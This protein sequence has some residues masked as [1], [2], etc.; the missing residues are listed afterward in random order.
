M[1]LS[2]L[3]LALMAVLS[4]WRG[5][6]AQ[7]DALWTG[8]SGL[9]DTPGNW[10]IN[11]V[12]INGLVTYNVA[13]PGGVAVQF[14]VDSDLFSPAEVADLDLAATS[15]LEINPG[16]VLHVLDDAMIGGRIV[17][18]G[19][20]TEFRADAPGA[21]F[22]GT[23]AQ[24][25]ASGGATIAVAGT[26]YDGTGITS[27]SIFSAAGAQSVVDVSS[28]Q[29]FD[30]LRDYGGSPVRTIS[31]TNGGLVDLSSLQTMQAGAGVGN[32]RLDVISNNAGVVDL[33]NLESITGGAIRFTS[34]DATYSLPSLTSIVGY[35]EFDLPIGSLVDLPEL[36]TQD[37]GTYELG[38]G[39]A[40]N[41][42][43]LTSLT[44]AALTIS[45]ATGTFTAPMLSVVD[46]SRLSVS[47]GKTLAI[48][49][50]SYLGT[51]IS[52]GTV[53][54]ADGG[55]TLLDL[56]TMTS[57]DLFRDFGG[58]PVRTI[59]ATN[60]GTIDLSGMTTLRGGA[61]ADNDRLDVV[62]TN[63]GVVDMSSL[64][65]ITAGAVRFMSDSPTYTL[66][67][68]TSIAAHVDFDLPAG[69]QINLPELVTQNLGA[70]D[71]GPGDA[72]S[73]PKLT[74]LTN[75]S[76][77]ITD[78]TGT[79][80][81]PLLAVIDHTRLMVS[82]GKSLAI[83][84]SSYV[85]TNVVS[86]EIFAAD[87][88]GTLLDLSAL[89]SVD[90]YRNFGGSPVRTI[91][92][93]NGG[94]IDLSGM[95]TL[96]GGYAAADDLLD[97]VTNTGGTIDLTGLAAITAGRVRF[98]SDTTYYSL[99]TLS[100][101]TA[102][103][104]YSMPNGALLELPELV[105]QAGGA[106]DVPIGGQVNLP[107][108]TTLTGAAITITDDASNFDAPLL[109]NIDHTR[110]TLSG[111]STLAIPVNAYHGS[112]VSSGVIFAA[113]G[114]DTVLDLSTVASFDN[115]RNFGG[116]PVRTISATNGGTIDLS[117]VNTLQGGWAPGDD[118]LDIVAATGGAIDL[119]NLNTIPAGNVR[120]VVGSGSTMSFGSPTKLVGT[121]I[122]LEDATARVDVAGSLILG[123]DGSLSAAPLS[124]VAIGQHHLF[125][126][127][128]TN[129]W[130]LDTAV[131][132]L[133]GSSYQFIEI[134]GEDLGTAGSSAGN[135]GIGQLVV[136]TPTL[137]TIATLVD[138]FDNGNQG[139]NGEPEA[140]YLY[141]LGGPDGLRIEGGS[142]LSIHNLNVYAFIDGAMTHLNALFAPDETTIEFDHG[143][144]TM[145]MLAPLFGDA[146]LDGRVDGL[147]YLA[148]ASNFGLSPASYSQGD[149]NFDGTVDG[150]DYLI[151]AGNF[152]ATQT[153]AV[154]E[155]ASLGLLLVGVGVM[156]RRRR[157][158][159]F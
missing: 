27:G 4:A 129:A 136:G 3:F 69:A 23:S 13:I 145:D 142:T 15:I 63:G 29:S 107:K 85:G 18:D 78:P 96:Q 130:N 21:A 125:A 133:D 91:S 17:A 48:P 35:V 71:L 159:A 106:Y 108:L 12:P 65:S 131:L 7:T 103:V 51:N 49:A 146:N 24:L 123:T 95:T 66:P 46:H 34:D 110:V 20:D 47:G 70:Y 120:F 77:T 141:G 157:R 112:D 52:S 101:I 59:A 151:W 109:T 137:P 1:K 150:L 84:A 111:G 72:V 140:L 143:F 16:H 54:S 28:L 11:T 81:A 147:D 31:A 97:V 99:P 14:D 128:D 155:P 154:P 19:T 80:D 92:A 116:A 86:G 83:P 45:N 149:F 42:P 53:F 5:G 100:S 26:S 138:V 93:T 73:A 58:S 76:L 68:L 121:A 75:A 89:T 37:G 6:L 98:T 139:S 56:A 135:F 90:V 115:L 127:T 113:D 60:G 33:S 41:V 57:V 148:W 114:T 134:G 32:D 38:A 44:N 119:S 158:A 79:F 67:A 94:T 87:G 9:Y 153:S 104:E 82:G 126:T 2:T 40:A 74:S 39:D 152:G 22:T 102:H 144:I 61:A 8:A 64:D 25:A 88:S 62:T 117:G 10:D 156:V 105:T 30:A 122:A 36:A 55:A 132:A 43:K 118:R 124:Q 50:T